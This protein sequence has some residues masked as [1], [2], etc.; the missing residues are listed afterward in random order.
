MKNIKIK[1]KIKQEFETL[2]LEGLSILYTQIKLNK[3]TSL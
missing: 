3:K 2:D 1:E